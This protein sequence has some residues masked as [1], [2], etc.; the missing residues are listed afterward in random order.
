MKKILLLTALMA[1]AMTVNAQNDFTV[2][3][4]AKLPVTNITTYNKGVCR[5]GYGFGDK[6]YMTD[7]DAKQLRVFNLATGEEIAQKEIGENQ[8]LGHDEVGNAI[9]G[10]WGFGGSNNAGKKQHSPSSAP[11]SKRWLQQRK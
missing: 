11:T 1:G 3:E 7:R 4:I 10:N 9:I 5:S 8:A 2:K 6:F